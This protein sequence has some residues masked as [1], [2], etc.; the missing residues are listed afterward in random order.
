[1]ENKLT[2]KDNAVIMGK[3]APKKVDE[4]Y[5]TNYAA[6]YEEDNPNNLVRLNIGCGLAKLKNYINLDCNPDVQ[7]DVLRNMERGLPF[8]DNTFDEILCEQTLEHVND[9]I[10]CMNE[11]HRV[12][13][14]GGILKLSV[15]LLSG[16]WAYIDPTHKRL[17]HPR[18]FDFFMV[19]DYNS[20]TAGVTGWY[21]CIKAN[22]VEHSI[23][24]T[25]AATK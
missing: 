17:F 20:M 2:L 7:P 12:L 9:L 8:N 14:P 1:M 5:A 19:K 24:L 4:K 11:I 6:G 25:L 18:S 3:P 10:F 21:K 13:K 22:I 23:Y 16:M 15:P